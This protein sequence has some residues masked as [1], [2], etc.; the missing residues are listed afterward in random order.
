ML[1]QI[2]RYGIGLHRISRDLIKL[3]ILVGK[4]RSVRHCGWE[5][6]GCVIVAHTEL[7]FSN[8]PWEWQLGRAQEVLLIILAADQP[9]QVPLPIL[10]LVTVFWR[11]VYFDGVRNSISSKATRDEFSS[12]CH[13]QIRVSI[14]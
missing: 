7:L 9:L 11:L 1:F 6:L 2:V 4:H 13:L 3:I 12:C 10:R 8:G 5:G 14:L